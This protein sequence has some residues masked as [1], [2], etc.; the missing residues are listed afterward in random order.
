M[1]IYFSRFVAALVGAAVLALLIAACGAATPTP[2]PASSALPPSTFSAPAP[3]Q[4]TSPQ[5]QSPLVASTPVSALGLKGRFVFA[6]GDGSILVEDA[7]KNDPRV[8]LKASQEL[9]ADAPVFSPDGKQIAFSVSSFT[10]DGQVLQDVRV[11]N[12]DGTN[13]RVVAT[14]KDPK[15]SYSFPAWSVDGKN[16]LI[17]QS[18]PVPPSSQHDEIDLVSVS[19]GPL[20]KVLEN[21]REATFSPD[22]K[23][24]VY[25]QL[26]Y[27]TY[28]SSLWVANIDGSGAKRILENNVFAAIYGARFSPDGQEIVF[29][30]SGPANKKLPGA[31]AFNSPASDGSCAVAFGVFC[32]AEKA[33]AHGLPWDLWLVSPDGAKFEQLT[34]IGADSPVPAWSADGKQIAFY[35]AT[36]VYLLDVA[37]KKINQIS[38]SHGYGGF[39]W[40]E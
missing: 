31:Y 2:T 23:K 9:Y 18:Y 16:L 17:T 21:A 37:T 6:L 30:E 34:H 1:K 11:M 24:I 20:R 26:D 5:Y 27:Q 13:M 14:P 29:A 19:G 4:S 10:K 7:G 22:G 33:E 35:D 25:S 3:S 36:G 8:V 32:F 28:S 38:D 12:V 39:D 15:I 40:R